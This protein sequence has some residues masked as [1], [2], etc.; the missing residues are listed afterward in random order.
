MP[1]VKH[2]VC[3]QAQDS[4]AALRAV[5]RAPR[6]LAAAMQTRVPQGDG[7]MLALSQHASRV[8]AVRSPAHALPHSLPAGGCR[9]RS[10]EAG[11][12]GVLTIHGQR[13]SV[14]GQEER[15]LIKDLRRD[16][17]LCTPLPR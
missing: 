13:L 4:M 2:S 8:L 5:G 17:E 15:S 10:G 3:L 9:F 12:A 1:W 16:V 11:W 14:H 6:A 7:A